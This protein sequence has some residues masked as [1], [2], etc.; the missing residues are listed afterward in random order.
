ME[1]ITPGFYWIKF[2]GEWTVG[3]YGTPNPDG[4]ASREWDI[5]ASDNSFETAELDAVGLR[6]ECPDYVNH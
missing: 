2:H 1:E 6:I 5:V 4:S 3:R